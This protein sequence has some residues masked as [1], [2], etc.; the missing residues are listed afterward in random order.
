[1]VILRRVLEDLSKSVTAST[2]Q[3]E[4]SIL[5]HWWV[6]KA[7]NFIIMRLNALDFFES[8]ILRTLY[9]VN[10][11]VSSLIPTS[12]MLTVRRDSHAPQLFFMLGFLI[13]LKRCCVLCHLQWSCLELIE[14]VC[15]GNQLSI[16]VSCF[17][18]NVDHPRHIFAVSIFH[19][20][21]TDA[22]NI[23]LWINECPESDGSISTACGKLCYWN[24]ILLWHRGSFWLY[25]DRKI[26][27]HMLNVINRP[28]MRVKSPI[29]C[30]LFH[31]FHIPNE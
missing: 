3:Q 6:V 15:W 7:K 24:H 20:G 12:Q 9:V 31:N 16:T 28:A 29:N 8:C 30:D 27:R 4:A 26:V 17:T 23:C 10:T 22:R 18:A 19:K 13:Y 2:C 14:K 1:M 21:F 11:N 25:P 5:I